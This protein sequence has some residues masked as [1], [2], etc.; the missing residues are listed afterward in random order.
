[1]PSPTPETGTSAAACRS[2]GGFGLLPVA[3]L[4]LALAA[5]GFYLCGY[6]NLWVHPHYFTD[7]MPVYTQDGRG[8]HWTDLLRALDHKRPGEYRPR[9]AMYCMLGLDIR[10]REWLYRHCC[11]VHPTFTLT[12]LLNLG[13][14]PLLLY[15]LIRN[16]GGARS[17]AL[18]SGAVFLSSI[19][20]LSGVTC[21][22]MP[23]KYLTT[24]ALLASLLVASE[25]YKAGDGSRLLVRGG[26]LRVAALLVTLFVGLFVDEFAGL[27][28]LLVPVMFPELFLPPKPRLRREVAASIC[29]FLSPAVLFLALVV[30]AVPAVTRQYLG[31]RFDFVGSALTYHDVAGPAPAPLLRLMLDNFLSLFG[32]ALLPD[33]L[34]KLT[35]HPSSTASNLLTQENNGIKVVVFALLFPYLLFRALRDGNHP[36]FL[37]RTCIAALAF[38]VAHSA[39]NARHLPV[40][41]GYYYGAPF[42]AILA[43]LCALFHGQFARSS[44]GF[45]RVAAEL[46]VGWVLL[47]QISNFDRINRSWRDA[48]NEFS[49]QAALQ[50]L[51]GWGLAFDDRKLTAGELH[52]IWSAW[53][54]G[55]LRQYLRHNRLS[56]GAAYLVAELLQ[57]GNPALRNPLRHLGAAGHPAHPG[58]GGDDR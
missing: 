1:M 29:V 9:F 56:P 48:H 33:A 47:V 57:P 3:C 24:T 2:W 36:N 11:C 7:I 6:R 39:L 40:T 32:T 51:P 4:V 18:L 38:L 12:W 14:A 5:L 21:Y 22:F 42:G 8:F 16:L 20:T 28:F 50:Q 34:S 17:S 13:V 25:I 10:A 53:R 37:L 44:G 26:R 49:R 58:A 43:L 27:A 54:G 55:E 35:P 46:A 15:R 41:N 31:Y 23:G 30:W 19:G 52:V 45:A